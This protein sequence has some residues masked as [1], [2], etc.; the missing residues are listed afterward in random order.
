MAGRRKKELFELLD[1]LKED[2]IAFDEQKL[3]FGLYESLKDPVSFY[4]KAAKNGNS[5]ALNYLGYYYSKIGKPSKAI[6]YYEEAIKNNHSRAILNLASLY[7]KNRL[8]LDQDQK[9]RI[10]LLKQGVD[11][12]IYQ[13]SYDLG[14]IY[15]EKKNY[16]KAVKYFQLAAKPGSSCKEK[17]EKELSKILD[18]DKNFKLYKSQRL[19][20]RV[21]QLYIFLLEAYF[22]TE[23]CS[24]IITH[25]MSFSGVTV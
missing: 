5:N 3:S 10:Q 8:K 2:D 9:K 7:K 1:Q 24:K 4:E 18:D 12:G 21:E 16:S 20:E 15:K 25:L 22:P 13:A 23:I 6:E 14:I 11:K 17:A 19:S